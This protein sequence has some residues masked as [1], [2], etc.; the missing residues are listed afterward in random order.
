MANPITLPPRSDSA[1]IGPSESQ[2]VQAQ[3]LF[4]ELQGSLALSKFVQDRVVIHRRYQ[5]PC[6]YPELL[7]L[8]RRVRLLRL[9]FWGSRERSIEPSK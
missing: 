7:E 9:S 5:S 3:L 2:K 6:G 1:G 4:A 8:E